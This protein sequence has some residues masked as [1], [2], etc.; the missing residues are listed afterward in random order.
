MDTLDSSH[1]PEFTYLP[2]VYQDDCQV[3]LGEFHHIWS[4]DVRYEIE[5]SRLGDEAE[6]RESELPNN[7]LPG[8]AGR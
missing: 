3:V 4:D 8:S 7:P 1:A 5:P 6:R 2:I